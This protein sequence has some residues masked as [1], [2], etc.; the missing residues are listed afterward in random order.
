MHEDLSI[1]TR[2]EI[3]IF[4]IELKS[5]FRGGVRSPVG[6]V[7]IVFMVISMGWASFGIPFSNESE[8]SP[9]SLGIYVIGFLVTVLLDATVI[10]K[11][12]GNDNPTEQTI[13][14]I[15]MMVSVILISWAS[16][17]SI[18]SF[19]VEPNKTRVGTWK[20]FAMPS[21]FIIFIVSILMSLVLTGLDSQAPEIGSLDT[22]LNT[23]RDR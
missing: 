17:L 9:E 10:W 6:V 21:L 3:K 18:K 14:G 13:A 1:F 20:N 8:I 5:K 12:T 11:R 7:Y 23:V 4:L 15:F 19:H 16:Y 22:S 2:E